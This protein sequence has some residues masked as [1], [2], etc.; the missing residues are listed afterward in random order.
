MAFAP[1]T[2]RMIASKC[3]NV[4]IIGIALN[5]GTKSK[6]IARIGK[7]ISHPLSTYA[8]RTQQRKHRTSSAPRWSMKKKP[9][10]VAPAA[11]AV[12]CRIDEF[13]PRYG[14]K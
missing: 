3:I 11:A 2:P 7:M 8:P 1:T 9:P 12:A 6:T 10:P 4:G 14:K 5:P 13:E